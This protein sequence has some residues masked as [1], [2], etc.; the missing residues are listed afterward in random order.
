MQRIIASMA[1]I[2]VGLVCAYSV[3]FEPRPRDS[4]QVAELVAVDFC[5]YSGWL[6]LVAGVIVGATAINRRRAI[7]N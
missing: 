5:Q 6:I 4:L 3:Y 2:L 1:L 7:S